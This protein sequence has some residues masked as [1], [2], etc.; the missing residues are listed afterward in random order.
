MF[1]F[2]AY[3]NIIMPPSR[4]NDFLDRHRDEIIRLNINFYA[5][6]EDGVS[7]KRAP[8]SEEA[9][10]VFEHNSLHHVFCVF[11]HEGEYWGFVEQRV[12]RPRSRI[13]TRVQ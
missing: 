9:V 2:A 4:F 6:N 1:P 13:R 3:G 5:N 8:D 12:N 7:I 10:G 11:N